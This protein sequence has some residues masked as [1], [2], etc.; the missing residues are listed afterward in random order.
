MAKKEPDV[1]EEQERIKK[2]LAA[3]KERWYPVHAE[4]R[5]V[6]RLLAEQKGK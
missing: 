1:H 3:A 6:E 5:R 2:L 4:V